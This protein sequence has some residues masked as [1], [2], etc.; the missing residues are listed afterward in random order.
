MCVVCV[1]L[2]VVCVS[3]CN[4]CVLY[5]CTLCAGLCALMVC[6]RAWVWRVLLR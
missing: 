1:F 4:V 6:A 5:S 3:I 2:C